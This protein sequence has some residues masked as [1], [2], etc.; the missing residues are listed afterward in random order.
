MLNSDILHSL[1]LFIPLFIDSQL[2]STCSV[3]KYVSRAGER[4]ICI[5]SLEA[6]NL[7]CVFPYSLRLNDFCLNFN[8]AKPAEVETPDRPISEKRYDPVPQVTSTSQY[9]QP[10][11]V[12][13]NHTSHTKHTHSEGRWCLHVFPLQIAF[14]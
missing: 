5:Q 2:M 13:V 14:L 1:N 12:L 8:R 9:T 3:L 11:P 6:R 4:S 10:S 7:L